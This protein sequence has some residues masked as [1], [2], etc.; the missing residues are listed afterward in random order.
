MTWTQNNPTAP[1]TPEVPLGTLAEIA[2]LT[3]P[4]ESEVRRLLPSA[5]P[6]RDAAAVTLT[7]MFRGEAPEPA[8]APEPATAVAETPAAGKNPGPGKPAGSPKKKS[9]RKGRRQAAASSTLATPAAQPAASPLANLLRKKKGENLARVVIDEKDFEHDPYFDEL[10]ADSDATYDYS[11]PEGF[12]SPGAPRVTYEYTAPVEENADP[13]ETVLITWPPLPG[14]PN[15]TT[16]YRVTVADEE[17]VQAPGAGSRLVVTHGT[18]FR[19]TRPPKTG[20]RHYQVWAYT[21]ADVDELLEMT[22]LF[23]GEDVAIFPPRNIRLAESGGTVSGTWEA[24]SGHNEVQIYQARAG[25]YGKLNVPKNE[26]VDGT[27]DQ[28]GFTHRVEVRGLTYD[29]TAV[30][31]VTFRG[32][33]RSGAPTPV[34]SVEVSAEIE[35]VELISVTRTEDD[36]EDHIR[37]EWLAPP[38]GS[39]KIF[40]TATPPNPELPMAQVDREYLDEDDALGST[41]WMTEETAPPGQYVDRTMVWPTG[42]YRVYVTPVNI[43]GDRA[44]VG[45]STVLQRVSPITEYRIIERVAGELITLDWPDGADFIDIRSA[46]GHH[47][48]D[49]AAYD[50]QGGIRLHLESTGERVTLTP[51]AVYAGRDKQSDS[52]TVVDYPGLRKYSYDL[53]FP[54]SGLPQIAVWSVD[55]PDS[56][57][58]H[59]RLVHNPARLPLYIGDGSPVPCAQSDASPRTRSRDDTD[60]Y[61]RALPTRDRGPGQA[62]PA[63]WQI[64]DTRLLP[65]GYLRLFIDPDAR[66]PQVTATETAEGAGST[67]ADRYTGPSG[68]DA[69]AFGAGPATPPDTAGP[70]HDAAPGV[71]NRQPWSA[72]GTPAVI[73]ESEVVARLR[74]PDRRAAGRSLQ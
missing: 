47:Q 24:R 41:E 11:M 59:F 3:D 19:D 71:D 73:L 70:A 37:I 23:L 13:T 9:G 65:G 61:Q 34:Q 58:P 69:A 43:V 36:H 60:L 67:A 44:W 57:A 26:L 64:D 4:T 8:P 15:A 52:P 7:G 1:G 12:V 2:A 22:P 50:R 35:Q 46:A 55:F 31:V 68:F 14:A 66:D 40:L 32:R 49:R 42:W 74:V 56:N 10:F 33:T 20:F 27:V 6:D 48:L 38:T 72:T 25:Y 53:D 16:L 62:G 54:D 5:Q 28:S 51:V 63:V 18:A 17:V 39:V 29:Y 30:P 21:G 45:E